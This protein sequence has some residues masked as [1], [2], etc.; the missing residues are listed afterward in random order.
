MF[1]HFLYF[2]PLKD[3]VEMLTN[4]FF[5]NRKLVSGDFFSVYAGF[6]LEAATLS[7]S[8][9]IVIMNMARSR[10]EHK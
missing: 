7:C 9:L 8:D 3:T 1:S 6:N 4:F 5:S 2:N 10:A